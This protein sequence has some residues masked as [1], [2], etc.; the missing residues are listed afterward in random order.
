MLAS[1][2]KADW[3]EV[4]NVEAAPRESVRHQP[5][6]LQWLHE[7]TGSQGDA[8]R[9][10]ELMDTQYTS[11]FGDAAVLSALMGPY[12]ADVAILKHECINHI[13]KRMFQGLAMAVK[14]K[15]RVG[16]P[17]AGK[18]SLPKNA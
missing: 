11:L 10:V 18:V 16:V 8:A 3:G 1:S 13:S 2:R 9:S 5:C 12:G 17:L 14:A 7:D 4:G 6:Q 15:S